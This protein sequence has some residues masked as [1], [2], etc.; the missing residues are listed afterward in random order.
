MSITQTREE[1]QREYTAA[2][3]HQPNNGPI[4]VREYYQFLMPEEGDRI[5]DFGAYTGGN[6]FKWAE[7]GHRIDGIEM[8]I[9]YVNRFL[10]VQALMPPWRE[11]ARMYHMM[12]ED[13]VPDG[14]YDVILCGEMLEHTPDP[15]AIVLK[16]HECLRSGGIFYIAV[17][18]KQQPTDKRLLKPRDLQ[19]LLCKNGFEI[20]LL[21]P[22]K[23]RPGRWGVPQT[24]CV[25]RKL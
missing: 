11:N 3:L 14:E 6:L 13:F 5:L 15:L 1:F 16:A 25:G 24:L 20:T 19:E 18:I 8:G 7:R 12:I 2:S 4:F 21:M 10:E 9:G 23:P 17:P 22:W